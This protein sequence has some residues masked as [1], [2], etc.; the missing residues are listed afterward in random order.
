VSHAE[1]VRKITGSRKPVI[2]VLLGGSGHRDGSE[3]QESVLALLGIEAAGGI[4]RCFSFDLP[5]TRVLNHVTGDASSETRNMLTESARIARGRIENALSFQTP[6][7]LVDGIDGLLVPGGS[8]I[9]ANFCDFASRGAEMQVNDFVAGILVAAAAARKPVGAICIAP[10]L[11]ARVLGALPAKASQ[12]A[13]ALK[14]TLG[15]DGGAA[16]SAARSWGI[17][18]QPCGPQEVCEDAEHRIVTTP[19]Y[20]HADATLE[21]VSAGIMQ[22]GRVLVDWSRA[23]VRRNA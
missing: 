16:V 9:A 14:L 22:L 12:H 8:G 21:Q 11:V 18:P 13:P 20:M 17:G 19:A 23:V 5:Q 3:I 7:K 10:L 15:P 1:F 6:A 4:P 2:G